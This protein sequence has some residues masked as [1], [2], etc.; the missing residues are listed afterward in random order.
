MSGVAS[1]WTLRLC[2]RGERMLWTRVE[3]YQGKVEPGWEASFR[4]SRG[5]LSVGTGRF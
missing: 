4:G 3:G 1:L 2:R 5:L